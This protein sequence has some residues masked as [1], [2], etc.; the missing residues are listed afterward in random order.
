[1]AASADR[2]RA[3]DYGRRRLRAVSEAVVVIPS[4]INCRWRS[5]YARPRRARPWPAPA[6]LRLRRPPA[7]RLDLRFDVGVLDLGNHLALR[8]G[9]FLELQPRQAPAGLHADVAAVPRD[10]VAAGDEHGGDRSIRLSP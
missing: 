1:M 2:T 7:R 6:A 9:A 3:A 8:T 5:S 10:H 4:F